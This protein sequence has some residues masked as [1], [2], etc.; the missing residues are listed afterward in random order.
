MN[1][2]DSEF[3]HRE[4]STCSN[5]TY[6][7]RSAPVSHPTETGVIFLSVQ[8]TNLSKCQFEEEKETGIFNWGQGKGASFLKMLFTDIILQ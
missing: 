8:D 6:Y 3:S 7:P 1:L 5:D 4:S 2:H